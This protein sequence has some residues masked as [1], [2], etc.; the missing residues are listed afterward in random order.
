MD[1]GLQIREVLLEFL[2]IYLY[3][4]FD[5]FAAVVAPLRLSFYN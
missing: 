4:L 5:V 2:T 3:V 1:H